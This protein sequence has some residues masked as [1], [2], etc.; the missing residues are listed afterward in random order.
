MK[1][2]DVENMELCLKKIS[3]YR[4]EEKNDFNDIKSSIAKNNSCLN[5]NNKNAFDH[6]QN[7]LIEKMNTLKK[8]HSNN[9]IVLNK[10]IEKQ[11]ELE[12][13]NIQVL[14]GSN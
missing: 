2:F 7:R 14:S 9:V 11:K 12:E 1:F 10:R 13:K 4:D 3:Y 5:T 6:V 8:I